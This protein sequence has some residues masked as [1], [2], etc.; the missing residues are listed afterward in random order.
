MGRLS[1]LGSSGCVMRVRCSSY[2]GATQ[3]YRGQI[4]RSS[5]RRLLFT[6]FS[7]APGVSVKAWLK[8]H[9]AVSVDVNV[10][11]CVCEP[12]QHPVLAHSMYS[13]RQLAA[14]QSMQSAPGSE[15]SGP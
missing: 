10:D 14:K 13:S 3:G 9:V 1:R 8:V 6:R 7:F 15:H 4:I 11:V 5:D 2:E 12:L